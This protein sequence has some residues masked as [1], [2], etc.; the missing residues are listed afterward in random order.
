[1]SKDAPQ[2]PRG[3]GACAVPPD[4]RR[5]GRE[6]VGPNPASCPL[7]FCSRRNS[8]TVHGS[9]GSGSGGSGGSH[10]PCGM[11]SCRILV[12]VEIAKLAVPPWHPP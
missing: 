4:A 3:S 6:A 5:S 9:D 1:M 2:A 7:A 10:L 11:A 12:A 8:R